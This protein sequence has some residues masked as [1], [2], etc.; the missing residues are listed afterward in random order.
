MA[1]GSAA[2]ERAE[3]GSE[4]RLG[5]LAMLKDEETLRGGTQ[6]EAD[7]TRTLVQRT[8]P[9]E[10]AARIHPTAKVHPYA[11]VAHSA[12][13]GA[14]TTVGEG[15]VI[16]DHVVVGDGCQLE[17]PVLEIEKNAVI[18][19]RCRV[20]A[21]YIGE[22]AQVGP[23]CVLEQGSSVGD[24]STLAENVC[25]DTD[26]A[27]E[28]EVMVGTGSTLGQGVRVKAQSVIGAGVSA[29]AGAEVGYECVV[30]DGVELGAGVHLNDGT[31]MAERSRAGK[32]SV[33]DR[34]RIGS[35]VTIGE[36]CR[37]AGGNQVGNG[38][39]F[40]DGVELGINTVAG[41]G[42]RI[43]RGCK[44]DDCC[45]IGNGTEIGPETEVQDHVRMPALTNVPKG[46]LIRAANFPGSGR[47][48]NEKAAEPKVDEPAAARP[49]MPGRA[50]AT[51]SQQADLPTPKPL[52]HRGDPAVAAPPA[53]PI[54]RYA[55]AAAVARAHGLP[56]RRS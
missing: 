48:P 47:W 50:A 7:G 3:I 12:R 5:K 22:H 53:R 54:R 56:V 55:A 49:T 41:S 15:V 21:S 14:D 31:T 33:I 39:L 40:E 24:Q 16:K 1:D 26:A 51:R 28:R 46:V 32:D 37:L 2:G 13:V 42:T 18:A 35:D 29:G 30:G 25:L 4:C 27:T 45:T 36:N 17:A 11:V 19:D 38:S 20:A 9:S 34:G 43:R 6:L 8:D 23:G 44:V 52:A 10:A